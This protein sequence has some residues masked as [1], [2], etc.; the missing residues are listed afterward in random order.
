[1]GDPLL[2]PGRQNPPGQVIPAGWCRGE[3]WGR[4]QPPW[5][6]GVS[7]ASGAEGRVPTLPWRRGGLGG[8]A[9]QRRCQNQELA[10]GC[11]WGAPQ[12]APLPLTA[13]LI[14]S[15]RTGPAWR[16]S[17][18]SGAAVGPRPT[19]GNFSLRDSTAAAPPDGVP[20]RG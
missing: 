2:P 18:P 12:Q 20:L 1:V 11:V 4:A 16:V 6:P 8:S 3:R 15:A 10:K 7:P 14:L 9:W 17:H 19:P 5:A 13:I